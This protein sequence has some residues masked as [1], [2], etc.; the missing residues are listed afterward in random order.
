MMENINNMQK[1]TELLK[2]S[3]IANNIER[4]NDGK[5]IFDL[6]ND[7]NLKEKLGRL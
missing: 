4:N 6:D 7:D 1:W 3:N 5:Y 2:F